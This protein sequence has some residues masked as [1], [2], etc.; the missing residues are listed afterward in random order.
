MSKKGFTAFIVLMTI[1]LSGCH[2]NSKSPD[3]AFHTF[4]E[5]SGNLASFQV[6]MTDSTTHEVFVYTRYSYQYDLGKLPAVITITSP[7]GKRG[8]ETIELEGNLENIKEFIGD[9]NSQQGIKLSQ[10]SEYYDIKVLY[11][12]N[13]HPIESGTWNID[14]YIPN[15]KNVLG[16]GIENVTIAEK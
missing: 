12:S 14:I 13:I 3:F 4:S 8:S 5:E 6:E 16:V 2:N 9:D 7:S 11:R 15:T 1:A 10:S